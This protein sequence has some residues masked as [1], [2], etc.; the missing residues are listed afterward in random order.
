[1]RLRAVVLATAA[2]CSIVLVSTAGAGR[3]AF[4]PVCLGTKIEGGNSG[5]FAMTYGDQPGT[6]TIAV[7]DTPLG[8]VFSF[9]TGNPQHVVGQ[10]DV[11]GGTS[12]NTYVYAGEGV[13]SAG[14]LHAA[15]NPSSGFWYGISYICFHTAA[16]GGEEGG[17]E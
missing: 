9:D 8:P 16:G 14:G 11:K 12:L 15:L 2:L 13:T 7:E 17:E 5:V 6:I 10:V 4:N 3:P 1:M